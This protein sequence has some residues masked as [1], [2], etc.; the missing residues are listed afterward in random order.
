M[1]VSTVILFLTLFSATS[2]SPGSS[3]GISLHS[4]NS[5]TGVVVPLS[6]TTT[7]F[8][9]VLDVEATL[10]NQSF[11]FFLDTGSS[12]LWVTRTDYNCIDD[13][14]NSI[15]SYCGYTPSTYNIST[16]FE[17]I[18]DQNFGVKYGA[19]LSS[20]IV[21][22]EKVTLGGLTIDKQEIGV[23]DSVSDPGSGND[24]GVLGLGYPALTS[25][26]PGRTFPNESI[27]FFT[28]RVVY[29][30]LFT[31]MYQSGLVDPYFSL[32]VARTPFNVS[33]G[34]GGFIGLGA[35][36][37]VSY[38]PKF[39][40]APVE[41]LDVLPPLFTN[42][43]TQK[44][45]WALTIDGT[46]YSKLGQP[47]TSNSTSFQA[48]VDSGNFF[49][50]IPTTEALSINSHFSP[51]ATP[52]PSFNI[53]GEYIVPCN[54]TPPTF[55]ITI[56]GQTLYHDPRDMIITQLDGTCLSAVAD[57]ELIGSMGIWFGILGTPFLT[58]VLAVFDFGRDEMRFAQRVEGAVTNSTGLPKPSGTGTEPQS[59]GSQ[60]I[61]S[62]ASRVHI[63]LWVV[64]LGFLELLG[65]F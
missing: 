60:V 43:I 61:T 26:H 23:C 21:G 16:T 27:A 18:P 34:G 13:S 25:A 11:K 15:I 9:T 54:A 17:Q 6:A 30:P 40:I 49:T 58:S 56:G 65:Q 29:N 5:K 42:N 52:S 50:Y 57:G 19:G 53:S 8:G 3:N 32:A 35:V 24:N 46:T 7:E 59:T 45:Y 22:F 64:V 36:P 10:G 55:G 39:A 63:G 14:D 47:T 48:I 12:D 38:N 28:N 44:S 62:S 41:I 4:R 1:S 33:N 51:P 31:N 2:A 37:P 20:G